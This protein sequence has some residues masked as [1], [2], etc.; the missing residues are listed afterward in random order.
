MNE[1]D[2][3]SMW[4]DVHRSS[5]E[6]VYGKVSIG[7][8]IKMKHSKIV[9][10]VLSDVK[11]R[12]L[13]YASILFIYICLMSYALIYLRLKLS[14]DSMIPLVLAGL[15]LTTHLIS[16]ISRLLVLIKAAD[17]LSVKESL[18]LFRKQIKRI[19][20]VDFLSYFFLLYLGAFWIVYCYLI[21]IGGAKNL[22]TIN[23]SVPL[24]LFE[25]F[26]ILLLLVPWSLIYQHNLR[27]RKL[28]ENINESVDFLRDEISN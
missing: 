11:L 4:G 17:S 7:Q 22:F 8:S 26:I 3:R 5:Q 20:A 24:P 9:Y 27:Y 14:V 10:K 18:L 13:V 16:E 6:V 25:F 28:Y 21:D 1:N 15:F 23:H 12:V 2:L 19:R